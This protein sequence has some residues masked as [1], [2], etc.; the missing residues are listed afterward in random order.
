M[1]YLDPAQRRPFRDPSTGEEGMTDGED[2]V[3]VDDVT[4]VW[5]GPDLISFVYSPGDSV[6]R[7]A[8]PFQFLGC[9][10]VHRD[11]ADAVKPI[12]DEVFPRMPE[13]TIDTDIYITFKQAEALTA[14]RPDAL[15]R[16]CD[17]GAVRSHGKGRGRL[18][19]AGDLARWMEK[20][21]NG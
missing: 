19:H 4:P 1:V 20:R 21:E 2:W 18:I 15:S 9:F 13:E 8:G 10:W 14:C 12:P 6:G 5:H 11:G 17:S 16:A 7:G 3:P